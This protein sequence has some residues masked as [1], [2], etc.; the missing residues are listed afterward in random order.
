MLAD[1]KKQVEV[2]QVKR[3]AV[4]RNACQRL[5]LGRSIPEDHK[6]FN[7]LIQ[8]TN[9]FYSDRHKVSYRHQG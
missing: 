4:L 9:L 2:L 3:Q 8:N 1:N 7:R 6:E 5:G